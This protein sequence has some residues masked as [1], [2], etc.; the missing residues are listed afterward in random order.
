ML[1]YLILRF[2]RRGKNT[3]RTCL[4][5]RLRQRV[6][7]AAAV[8]L[9]KAQHK[10]WLSEAVYVYHLQLELGWWHECKVLLSLLGE[11]KH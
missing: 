10:L 8:P 7:K 9:R 11:V 3:K 6:R 5:R 2:G 1:I 4:C